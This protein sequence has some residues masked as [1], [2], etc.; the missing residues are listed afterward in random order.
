MSMITDKIVRRQKYI[1]FFIA[2]IPKNGDAQFRVNL[3]FCHV[4]CKDAGFAF[5]LNKRVLWK[6]TK[7]LGKC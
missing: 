1:F 7:I 2:K 6:T 3:H 4:I 5:L